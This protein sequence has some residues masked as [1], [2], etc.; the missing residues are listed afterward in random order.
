MAVR[1]APAV[2]TLIARAVATPVPKPVIPPTGSVQFVSVPLDGVPNA[3]PLVTKAPAEPTLIPSAVATPV[4][5]A[6]MP[7][8]PRDT[9]RVPDVIT[10]ASRLRVEVATP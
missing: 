3:P 8:P 2:P 10:E 6:V 7:V 9:G 1:N 5:K 4:P